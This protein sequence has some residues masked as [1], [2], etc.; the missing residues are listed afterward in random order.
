LCIE[1]PPDYAFPALSHGGIS[2]STRSG[3]RAFR[4][5]IDCREKEREILRPRQ[6][7]LAVRYFDQFDRAAFEEG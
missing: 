5:L 6:P 3:K 1:H 2:L 4:K 7:M